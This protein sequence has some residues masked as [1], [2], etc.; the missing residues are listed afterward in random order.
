MGIILPAVCPFTVKLLIIIIF[1]ALERKYKATTKFIN[2]MV[3]GFCQL[4]I[5]IELFYRS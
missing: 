1:E 4:R 3:A 5:P 2:L